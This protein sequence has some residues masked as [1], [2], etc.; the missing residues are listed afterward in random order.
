MGEIIR[1][2]TISL[3]SALLAAYFTAYFAYR[4]DRYIFI[5]KWM[6]LLRDEV[7]KYLGLCE[8]LRLGSLD[9]NLFDT[10]Y[11]NILVSMHKIELLL[12][13]YDED[14][15]IQQ[16]L[17]QNVNALR[18]SVHNNFRDF[19]EIEK[20]I[21]DDAYYLLNEHWKMINSEFKYIK[22]IK[23]AGRKFLNQLK[24]QK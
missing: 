10:L 9:T 1:T 11:G 17:L 2:I 13:R 21:V 16:S 14:K 12:N 15:I 23:K 3:I 8:Q 7:S 22:E 19:R 24:R 18:D 5:E 4:K 6:N 20:R